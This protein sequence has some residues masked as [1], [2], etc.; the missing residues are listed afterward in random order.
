MLKSI[1]GHYLFGLFRIVFLYKHLLSLFGN[2]SLNNNLDDLV[3][4]HRRKLNTDR[5]KSSYFNRLV[6]KYDLAL[7]LVF[8]K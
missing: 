6:F 8:C 4:S 3:F 1:N 7:L 2:G 5:V